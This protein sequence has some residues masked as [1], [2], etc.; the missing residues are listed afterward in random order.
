MQPVRSSSSSLP[1][2]TKH[3]LRLKLP[4]LEPTCKPSSKPTTNLERFFLFCFLLLLLSY[5]DTTNSWHPYIKAVDPKNDLVSSS[6]RL[7]SLRDRRQGRHRGCRR[8]IQTTHRTAPRCCRACS[9][10]QVC[11]CREVRA[12]HQTA[13]RHQEA[14]AGRCCLRSARY[15]TCNALKLTSS[16]PEPTFKP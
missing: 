14:T 5:Y 11:R 9:R 7:P 8:E 16:M 12:A 6:S 1:S 10:Q 13:A 15:F 2:S 3:V 4:T